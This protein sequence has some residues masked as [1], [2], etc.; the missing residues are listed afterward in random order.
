MSI[1][2]FSG[3]L[4]TNEYIQLRVGGIFWHFLGGL[5]IYLLLFLLFIH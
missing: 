1:R 5:W 3:R 4:A 2:S